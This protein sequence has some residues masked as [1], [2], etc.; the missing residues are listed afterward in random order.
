MRPSP[1]QVF[2][3]SSA[4]LYGTRF[5]CFDPG[6]PQTDIL[7]KCGLFLFNRSVPFVIIYKVVNRSHETEA[8]HAAR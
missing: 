6:R 5:F 4:I 1:D 2:Q 8:V 7:S 3:V